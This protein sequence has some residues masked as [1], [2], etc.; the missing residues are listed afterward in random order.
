MRSL[1]LIFIIVSSALTSS[2]QTIEGVYTNTW[3]SPSGEAIAFHL[4]LNT[5]GTFEF[6]L[7]RAYLDNIPAYTETTEGTWVLENHLLTLKTNDKTSRLSSNLN[8]NKARYVNTSLRNP[9]SNLVHPSFK[10]YQSDVF[11]AKGM[12]L[13]KMES[14]LKSSE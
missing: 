3:E 9:N 7:T 14:G 13:I 2:A 12:E 6:Q 10:F 1:L 8:M 4:S 11:Y 5:D